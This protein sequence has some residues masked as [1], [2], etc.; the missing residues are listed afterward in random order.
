MQHQFGRG[1]HI[2]LQSELPV[3]GPFRDTEVGYAVPNASRGVTEKPL[4][5]LADEKIR[6]I[7]QVSYRCK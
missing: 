3:V 4:R 6:L 7:T 5:G 1:S 2:T